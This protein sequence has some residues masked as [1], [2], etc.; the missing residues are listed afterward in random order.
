M[1]YFFDESGQMSFKTEE[2]IFVVAGFYTDNPKEIQKKMKIWFQTKFPRNMKILS[3]IKWTAKISDELRISTLTC[4]KNLDISIIFKFITKE[5]LIK[6]YF[7]F[8][9]FDSTNVYTELLLEI[10]HQHISSDT[11]TVYIFCDRRPLYNITSIDFIGMICRDL[12]KRVGTKIRIE[13]EMIDSTTSTGIQIADWIAGAIARYVEK[14]H[15]WK[16]I[17][18]IF[19]LDIKKS[20]R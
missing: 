16:E 4:L 3:E 14:G 11:N 13:M 8:R 20:V 19:E 9:K 1:Y 17:G 6:R 12:K 2:S 15:L 7:T 5:E 18:Q 10:L